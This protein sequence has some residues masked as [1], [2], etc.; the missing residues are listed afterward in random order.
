ME[1]RNKSRKRRSKTRGRKPKASAQASP[2]VNDLEPKAVEKQEFDIDANTAE[3]VRLLKEDVL[4]QARSAQRFYGYLYIAG[5]DGYFEQEKV[6]TVSRLEE[7]IED[8]ESGKSKVLMSPPAR[9]N[10]R[11]LAKESR[12]EK[13]EK[14]EDSKPEE[15]EAKDKLD[16][17]PTR[18]FFGRLKDLLLP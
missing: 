14:K 3:A 18:G 6:T 10:P 4:P 17:Q 8:V 16:E 11:R 5:E 2:R 9:V 13:V 7:I 12:E 15:Y 1:K